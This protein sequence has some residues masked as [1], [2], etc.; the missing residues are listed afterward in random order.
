MG[1]NRHRGFRSIGSLTQPIVNSPESLVS[2]LERSQTS[3]ATTGRPSPAARPPAS[4]GTPPSAT[5]AAITPPGLV[6]TGA[7]AELTDRLLLASLPPS[8]A[9]SLT[10]TMRTWDDP[11][12]GFDY[13]ITGYSLAEPLPSPADIDTARQM[14]E[15]AMQPAPAKSVA[16]ELARLAAVTKSRADPEDD[17]TLRFAA[18]REELAEFPRDVITTALRKIARRETFFPSLAEIRDQCQREFSHRKHLADVLRR[19]A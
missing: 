16:A 1:E 6:A 2:T 17:Q 5:P 7:D 12:H 8:V 19:S 3:S 15:A 9:R 18:F 11:V 10:P 13:Q 14:V 4:I